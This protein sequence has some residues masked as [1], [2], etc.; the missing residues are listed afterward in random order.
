METLSSIARRFALANAI[1][2]EGK[3]QPKSVLGAALGEHPELRGQVPALRSAVEAECESVN[4]LTMREQEK[5][6]AAIGG[7]V[8]Q[9]KEERKGLPELDLGREGFVVRF[10]PNPDGALHLG[11]ARPAVLC[12]EY[13]KKYKGKFILRFDDTDPKVKT[14]EKRFYKMIRDDLKWLK[15]RVHKEAIASKRLN[16]YYQYAEKLVRG[17]NAYV[18]ECG[19][20]WKAFRD[21]SS[22]CPCRSLSAK[23][24]L[25]RWQKML[26]HRYKEGQAVLRIKTDMQ[27]KNPAVRDWPAMR[28]VDKPRHP[29]AKR[30]LWPLYNFASAIDDKLLGITHIFRGQEHSTN[31]TKQRFLYSYFSWTY[32]TVVTLGRFSLSDLMLSK[33]SIREGIAKRRYRDWDDVRL[34]TIRALS[35]RGFTPE[36]VRNI[37]IDVGPKPSD[38]TIDLEN[39]AS[40]N[41]K[42]I[43]PVANR[44]FFIPNPKRISVKNMRIKTA[45]LPLHPEHKRGW[46]TFRLT[47]AFYIDA[48]DFDTYKGLEVR[49][50]ELCNVRLHETAEYTGTENKS[51]PKIQWV[52]D[53]HINVNMITPA[54]TVKGYAETNLLKAR[55]GDIVQFE[56]VGFVRIE[57]ISRKNVVVVFAHE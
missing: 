44:Y 11:N 26:K 17:G 41:R 4:R 42:I 35:R 27:A 21:K 43:D 23:E 2:H 13:A 19:D 38:I 15:I 55:T 5:Q 30:H 18:C 8:R 57:K 10:A 50:K 46:R 34:G 33:S 1:E 12:D 16:I 7:F 49:L 22:A 9:H 3:A 53:K 28:I 51:V 45:K 24:Q 29:L 6:L 25:K 20:A 14:P 36:A 48:S 56:R 47:N 40:Y 32:P 31:E 54:G 39:L 37:I 52:P